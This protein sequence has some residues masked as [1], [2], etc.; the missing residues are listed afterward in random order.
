MSLTHIRGV[1]N[2]QSTPVTL[3]DRENNTTVT[4]QPFT[5]AACSLNVP[6]CNNQT[7]FEWNHF[8]T[9]Q[10]G[11]NTIAIWQEGN[12]VPFSWNNKFAYPGDPAYGQIAGG[13]NGPSYDAR[14]NADV[15]LVIDNR[16]WAILYR[17]G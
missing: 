4:C 7:D 3:F 14:Y 5:T 12:A 16:P 6:W 9:L 2:M 10:Y 15:I 17:L 13:Y 8:M 1:V 11:G